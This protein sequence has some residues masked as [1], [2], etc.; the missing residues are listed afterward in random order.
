MWNTIGQ[1]MAKA[2]NATLWTLG[3]DDDCRR[4]IRGRIVDWGGRADQIV[5]AHQAPIWDHLLRHNLADV[6]LDNPAY[7]G[8]TT[9]TDSYWA[10]CPTLTLALEKFS[11]RYGVSQNRGMGLDLFSAR[12]WDDF[13]DLGAA[14]ANSPK[15]LRKVRKYIEDTRATQPLFD[16]RR[17]VRRF[18]RAM[19]MTFETVL[20]TGERY[21]IVLTPDAPSDKRPHDTED[22]VPMEPD[23]DML[24]EG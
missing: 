12:T 23:D 3:D 8:G 13:R 10:G 18:Q 17:W 7:N 1:M 5:V 11:A 20:F 16:T 9:G 6:Y 15:T 2:P 19:S 14:L 24:G 22:P 4:G 21:H